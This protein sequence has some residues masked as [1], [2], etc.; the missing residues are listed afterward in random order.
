MYNAMH[1]YIQD[2]LG[3]DSD[4]QEIP[5]Q[6]TLQKNIHISDADQFVK[7]AS[8]NCIPQETTICTIITQDNSESTANKP[9]RPCLYCGVFHSQLVRHLKRKHLNEEAVAAA[10]K[11]PKAK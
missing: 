4:S 6:L 5:T 9:K 3:S 7:N 2:S 8:N 10:I 11:L 1:T